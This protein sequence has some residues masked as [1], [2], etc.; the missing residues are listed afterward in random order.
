VLQLNKVGKEVVGHHKLREYSKNETPTLAMEFKQGCYLGVCYRYI[1][2][3]LSLPDAGLLSLN[4][5][6][7]FMKGCSGYSKM[8]HGRINP[9]LK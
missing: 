4:R 6:S 7:K 9:Y 2:S 8:S 3:G 1:I 5:G